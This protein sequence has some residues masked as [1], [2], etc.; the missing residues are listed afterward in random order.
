MLLQ[1]LEKE[2]KESEFFDLLEDVRKAIPNLIS[3]RDFSLLSTALTTLD[4]LVTTIR[5]DWRG[6]VQD[7]VMETDFGQIA[8][9]CLSGDVPPEDVETIHDLLAKF[10]GIAAPPLLNRLLI[11]P[12]PSRRRALIKILARLGPAVVPDAGKRVSHPHTYFVRN[13][14]TILG[15]VGD[16]QALAPL[17]QAIS[18]REHRGEAEAVP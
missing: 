5:E 11:E 10:G 18:P 1:L 9:L 13:L 17:I 6:R 3:L 2:P 8:D 7:V 12:D 16:R 15:D 14:C 4:S